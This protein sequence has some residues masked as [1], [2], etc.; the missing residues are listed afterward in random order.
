MPEASPAGVTGDD[1][2]LVDYLCA[3]GLVVVHSGPDWT[4]EE[5]SST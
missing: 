4:F 2:D 5:V 1:A 3:D